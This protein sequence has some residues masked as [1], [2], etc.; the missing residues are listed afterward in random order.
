MCPLRRN[1]NIHDAI[2]LV[3]Q[4]GTK[5]CVARLT[6]RKAPKLADDAIHD[7]RK[8]F[9]ALRSLV[10][11]V[12][13]DMGDWRYRSVNRGL[14]NASLPLSAARDAKVV[15]TTCNRIVRRCESFNSQGK[16]MITALERHLEETRVRIAAVA[17]TRRTIAANL[18]TVERLVTDWHA[19]QGSWKSLSRG[20]RS[21]YTKGRHA[22]GIATA[23]SSDD[24]LH[25]LRKRSKDLLYACAF[26]R[27]ASPRAR[28]TA[29]ALKR[30]TELLGEHRDL[31]M[32]QRAVAEGRRVSERS[33][34]SQLAKLVSREEAA[35]R[36]R[37]LR[38][39]PGIYDESAATFVGH[40]H[41]DWKTWRRN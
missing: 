7:L 24:N 25:E 33:V 16:R 29:T 31:G 17:D 6:G 20:L 35:L 18:R 1:E 40:V 12:R 15:L 22:L 10:K 2:Q 23:D 34:R 37:A 28:R 19:S 4:R 30:F 38:I 32:L 41:R 5:S 27:K 26:L 39:G 11:L 8:Q 13:D 21:M 3:V 14:R 9:K 36:H